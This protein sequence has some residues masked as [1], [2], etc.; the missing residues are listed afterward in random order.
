MQMCVKTEHLHRV[1]MGM[2]TFFFL[3]FFFC[4]CQS[5]LQ[6][7]IQVT[8]VILYIPK[9]CGRSLIVH[10]GGRHISVDSMEICCHRKY[11]LSI[12]MA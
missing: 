6:F 11:F 7:I 10:E 4:L 3:L 5:I 2:A 9:V 8:L 12:F 1:C